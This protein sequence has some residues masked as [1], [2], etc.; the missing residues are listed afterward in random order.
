MSPTK[1]RK[2]TP[3][4]EAASADTTPE[5]LTELA[6]DPKLARLVAAN[7]NASADLLL[8]LSH[9]EDKTVRKACTSNADTPVEALLKLGGQLPEQLLCTE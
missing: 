4:Q 9:N 8:E 2:L 3:R 1:P 5:R 7:P 6:Q